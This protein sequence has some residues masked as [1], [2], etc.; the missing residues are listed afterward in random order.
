[1]CFLMTNLSVMLVLNMN[2]PCSLGVHQRE[3]ILAENGLFL[4][5]FGFVLVVL[6]DVDACL[7]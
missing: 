6:Q 1:M 7:K 5:F 3:T 2:R 4:L